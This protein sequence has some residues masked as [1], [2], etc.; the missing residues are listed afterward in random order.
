MR[1]NYY[2]SLYAGTDWSE[3]YPANEPVVKYEQEANEIFFRPQVDKFI[4]GRTNNRIIYDLLRSMYFDVATFGTDIK[5]KINVLGTD[6]FFFVNPI[7]SGKFNSENGVYE[8]APDP[9]DAYRKI[10]NYYTTK[11]QDDDPNYIFGTSHPYNVPT[12]NTNLFVNDDFT[13]F[14][15][16]GHSVTWTDTAHGP[17]QSAKCQLI[18]PYPISGAIISVLISDF[19]GDRFFLKTLD[20]SFVDSSSP[21]TIDADGV[22]KIT[23]TNQ[24]A[25]LEMYA[26]DSISLSGSF[27]YKIFFPVTK[28]SGGLLKDVI[29]AVLGS[30][31][32]NSGINL[33]STILWN[34]VLET[35]APPNILAYITAN[36]TKDYVRELTAIFNNIWIARTDSLTTTKDAK[37]QVSLSDVMN[38]LKAKLRLWWFIDSD[39]YFRIEHEKYFRDYQPQTDLTS[40]PYFI[41][42]PEID[43]LVYNYELKDVYKQLVFSENN[44]RT[45]KSTAEWIVSPVL[46][47][48]VINTVPSKDIS[49]SL[50]TSDVQYV[51]EN[52][53]DASSPG[54][55]LMTMEDMSGDYQITLDESIITPAKYIVNGNLS[56][57]F[58]LANYF[59]YFAE[60]LTGTINGI[61]H[62]F[63]HVKEYLTQN[64]IGFHFSGDL[65]WKK[66]FILIRGIGWLKSAEHHPETGFY[67]INVGFNPYVSTSVSSTNVTADDATVTV[68]DTSI[69][70]D[71]G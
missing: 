11:Y 15:D 5:Y 53:G 19:I 24:V 22:Y 66:P 68:D 41:D 56:W 33:R 16:S 27:T 51:S 54:L 23:A 52:P 12:L 57:S 69:T 32:I 64:N 29:G 34:D 60:A 70:A 49:V 58:L 63:K 26:S 10:M 42:K 9:D 43:N 6:K 65:N 1:V 28:D 4:I 50:L 37:S 71:N 8:A 62:T 44:Q 38:I 21:V 7:T 45:D 39:G 40:S 13:T 17:T 47:N 31:Y 36:P 30:S 48:T 3:F 2:I 59:D 35:D 18:G 55:V 67:I 61:A 25:Y 14:A 46:F 20:A